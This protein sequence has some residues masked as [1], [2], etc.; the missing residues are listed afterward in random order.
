MKT[1]TQRFD[2][3]LVWF[4]GVVGSLLLIFVISYIVDTIR[5]AN[6]WN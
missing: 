3:C 2:S 1:M 5:L 6:T 4:G